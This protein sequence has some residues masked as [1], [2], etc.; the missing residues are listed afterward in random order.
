MIYAQLRIRPGKGDAQTS[1]G[2]RNTNG[3]PNFGRTTRPSYN[4][5]KEKKKTSRVVNF[6]VP[7]DHRIKLKEK[8]KER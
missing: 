1:L 2:F 4:Q 8:R 3:S 7:A 5:Q 6:A